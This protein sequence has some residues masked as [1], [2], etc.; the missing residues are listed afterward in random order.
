MNAALDAARRHYRE[1]DLPRAEA[2]FREAV[3]LRP[4]DAEA[5]AG[6]GLTLTKSG[7]PNEAAVLL[8]QVTRLTPKAAEAHYDLG[9]ALAESGRLAEAEACFHEALRLNPNCA[10]AHGNLGNAYEGQ[11]RFAEALACYQLAVWL[12]PDPPGTVWNRA[13]A[14]LQ[15]GDFGRRV[16]A[17][18]VEVAPGELIDKITIL[19]IKAQ[20]LADPAKL[21]QVRRELDALR[22][23]RAGTVPPS[24][25]LAR[26]EAALKRVNATLWEV[27]DAIRACERDQ[28]FGPRFVELAR[29]VY[30]TND[31]RSA[32]KRQI[33]ELL[34]APFG[35]QKAYTEYA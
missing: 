35:E 8:R 30:R 17:V 14:R 29:S 25:E 1:G 31:A 15:A 11:G 28:D 13:L 5:L 34:G 24:D 21:A 10:E 20:R 16:G 6:L 2:A 3:R 22:R 32:L 26:L 19:E 7:R 4:D 18:P 12:S 27:E 9:L 33:N 23:A